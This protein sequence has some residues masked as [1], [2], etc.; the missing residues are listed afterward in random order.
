MDFKIAPIGLLIC[1]LGVACGP[2]D[3]PVVDSVNT[4][5]TIEN[6]TSL[7]GTSFASSSIQMVDSQFLSSNDFELQSTGFPVWTPFISVGDFNPFGGIGPNGQKLSG[8][9][10]ADL[11]SVRLE[12]GISAANLI[13]AKLE[14]ETASGERALLQVSGIGIGTEANADLLY[15]VVYVLDGPDWS[16]LCG[17][18]SEGEPIPAVAVPGS[19]NL[20]KGVS[21]G[22][23]WY[24]DTESFSFACLGSSI[25]KCVEAGYKPW[26]NPDSEEGNIRAR[27]AAQMARPNHLQACVRM[28][29]A[30]YC[31]DGT[32]H[33]VDGRVIEFWDTMGLHNKTRAEFTFEA[34][35]TPDGALFLDNPRVYDAAN[36]LPSCHADK[37]RSQAWMHNPDSMHLRKLR[38]AG[39][40]VFSAYEQML[41]V[42]ERPS[43][44]P[45]TT[46]QPSAAPTTKAMRWSLRRRR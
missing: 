22:G 38:G 40:L 30:D 32:A 25:A 41:V 14:G 12:T 26:T 11:K 24:G 34:G 18:S 44:A 9:K 43:T 6:G 23:R 7:N 35:W 19:W 29:R 42:G 10:G 5:L 28:L 39:T 3:A 21:D 31:G 4:G 36:G 16:P 15:Y 20:S 8:L 1:G 37:H 27:D 33:T 2:A 17:T 46:I 13:G 45:T